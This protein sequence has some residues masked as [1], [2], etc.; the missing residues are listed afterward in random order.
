[1]P[2]V[3]QA[4]ILAAGR[5]SRLRPHTDSAPKCL[6]P[7]AGRCLFDWQR[8]ALGANGVTE[9]GVVRGY[10]GEAFDNAGVR[11]WDNREWDKS[12]M[13]H[14]LFCARDA[15]ESAEGLVIAYGDIVYEPRVVQAVLETAGDIVVAVDRNWLDL[16]RARSENPLDDAE[17]LRIDANGY[18]V[19]IGRK[20]TSLAEIEAQYIGLLRL[21]KTGLRQLCAFYDAA[22]DG[23]AWMMGRPRINCYMTDL[24]RGLTES[25]VRLTAAPFAGGWLEFDTSEDLRV[26]ETMLAEGQ[27]DR[28][29][30]TA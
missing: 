2:G 21:S 1:M 14:S 8:S 25:G 12:N 5:G 29:F 17:T 24:L 3:K 28:F 15:L 16:W 7:F 10:R 4:I 27:L 23:S 19:D 22:M 30:H 20:P 6:L 13:V 11:V 26:Y 18:I 9:I